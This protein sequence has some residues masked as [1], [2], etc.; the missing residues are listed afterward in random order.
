MDNNK[1]FYSLPLGI[2]YQN[3]QGAIIAANPAAE[4]ILGISIDQMQGKKS[5]DPHWRT[6]KEDGSDFPGEEHPAMMA[7]K[8]NKPINNVIMGV[9]HPKKNDHVWIEINAIPQFKEGATK[10]YQVYT[11]FTDITK[12]I[13][14]TKALS[15]SDENESKLSKNVQ[16]CPPVETSF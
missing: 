4:K 2:V 1:L 7:L 5:I 9:F 11:T 16:K 6:I 13:L 15:K 8:N 10:P 3:P 12:R 14:S